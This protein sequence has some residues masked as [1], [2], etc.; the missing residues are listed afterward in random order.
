VSVL[1]AIFRERR[2]DAARAKEQTP[3]AELRARIRDVPP[4]RGFRQALVARARPIGLIAEIK[5]ASPSQGVI[6]AD[7][8]VGETAR[9]YERAGA[10]ALSVLT[11]PRHFGGALENLALAREA[12][13]LPALRK[14]FLDDPYQIYEA[15]AAGADAVLLIVAALTDDDLAALM[16][17]AG[18]LGMDALVEVH[19]KA[20]AERARRAGADLV[21]VNSR[22]LAT[23]QTDL[24]VAERILPL[25]EGATRVAESALCTLQD[26]ERMGRAGADAVLIGTA[27]CAAEDLEAKV[28]EVMGWESGSRSAG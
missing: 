20:E 8:D 24:A 11:E 5:P 26:V 27:F 21:G 22:D 28:R 9:R 15:R 1:E 25:L 13:A 14:D 10:H 7:L 2:Q 23:L 6:R 19:A 4:P 12:C 3:L 18:E 16:E 17:L